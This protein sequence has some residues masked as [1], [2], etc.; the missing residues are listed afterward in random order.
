MNL[1]YQLSLDNKINETNL[2]GSLLKINDNS[3]TVWPSNSIYLDK[4]NSNVIWVISKDLFPSYYYFKKNIININNSLF[5]LLTYKSFTNYKAR[6]VSLGWK[7]SNYT[8]KTLNNS[9]NKDT[10]VIQRLNIDGVDYHECH[11]YM[12]LLLKLV[13]IKIN[14]PSDIMYLIWNYI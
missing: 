11:R 3:Y 10:V 1:V 14:Y 6:K 13:I 4:P 9:G 8:K 7:Y 2:F 12:C 5:T